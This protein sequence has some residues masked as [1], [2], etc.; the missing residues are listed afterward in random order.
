MSETVME[1]PILYSKANSKKRREAREQYI[2]KQQGLCCFCN[3]DLNDE[4]SE[5]ME[6]YP[7]NKKL[8]PIGMFKN[9]VHLHHCHDTDLTI[10][11]V[12]AYCNAV[13]WQYIG[14]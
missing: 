2:K 13:L 7:I 11:A 1:L 4:P 9:P 6:K 12:H 8:F 10:G 3:K 14:E 5:L